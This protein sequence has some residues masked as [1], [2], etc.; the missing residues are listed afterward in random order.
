MSSET[1]DEIPPDSAGEI[2][3]RSPLPVGPESRETASQFQELM[4]HLEQAFWIKNAADTAV[5]YVSPAY[6]KI[7]GRSRPS[8]YNNSHTFLD[9]VHPEDRAR[10]TAAMSSKH[11]TGGD[12]EE[13]R[14]NRPDGTE[15]W[16]WARTYPV[17]DEHGDIKR[18]AGIAVDVSERKWSE[19]ERSRL[20]AIIEHTED[21]V[22]STTLDGIIIA[23]NYGAERK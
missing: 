17:R 16:I 18:Y 9:S 8:L 7:W 19:K 4:A 13:Y 20:A 10:V 22:V 1:G 23:W 21:A 3:T 6:E 15:R 5:R 14:I 12:E 11:E 2:A